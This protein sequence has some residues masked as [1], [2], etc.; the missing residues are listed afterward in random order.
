METLRDE[1]RA[2]LA[3]EIAALRSEMGALTPPT[4]ET[5]PVA[6]SSDL[7]RFA[8]DL[9]LRA[10]QDPGF[11]QKVQSGAHSFAPAGGGYAPVPVSSIMTGPS[12]APARKPEAVVLNK[13]L[14]TETDLGEL[15]PGQ[16]SIRVSKNCVV[17][18]LARDEARRLGI[19]IERE[20]T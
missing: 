3:E 2:I 9:L 8:R 1:I 13:K 17:T 5:V 7:T 4:V 18:P 15:G 19:R 16:K 12:N 20:A 10:S 14:I 6:S 11:A